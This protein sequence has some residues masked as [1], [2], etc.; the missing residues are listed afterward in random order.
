MTG[1]VGGVQN[2]VVE[3]GE[4]ERKTETNGVSRGQLSLRDIS[5]VL[6]S[7]KFDDKGAFVHICI[8]LYASWAAVAATLRFS[9]DA[10]SAR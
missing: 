7:R 5:S 2:L 9:P 10:N 4:I 3:N 1:T 8:T 6:H